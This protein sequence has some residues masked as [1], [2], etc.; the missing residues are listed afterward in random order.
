L[1]EIFA[2]T[3]H[4]DDLRGVRYGARLFVAVNRDPGLGDWDAKALELTDG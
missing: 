1:L 4:I 2:L 3:F